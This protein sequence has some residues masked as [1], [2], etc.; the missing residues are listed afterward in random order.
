MPLN[1]RV[2]LGTVQLRKPASSP[3]NPNAEPYLWTVFFKIDDAHG[4]GDPVA[5]VVGTPGSHGNL[6]VGTV[7]APATIQVPRSI[8]RWDTGLS[9]LPNRPG[10]INGLVRAIVGM[11]AVL[12]EEDNVTDD[13]AEAGRRE[14]RNQVQK[15]IDAIA[16]D[17]V[18][19]LTFDPDA[20]AATIRSK[21]ED[22]I[23]GE[24]NFLED[25]WSFLDKDDFIGTMD[26]HAL[27][28]D[29]ESAS[30]P[31]AFS[32]SWGSAFAEWSLEGQARTF[33]ETRPRFSKTTLNFGRVQAG[34][35]STR[36]FTV[37]N[38][39]NQDL[40]F[41]LTKTGSREF[42][43]TTSTV[44]VPRSKQASVEMRFLPVSPGNKS[45][46]VVVK[47]QGSSATEATIA[48][49]GSTPTGPAP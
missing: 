1:V 10:T 13:G 38:F 44:T 28:G 14:L 19:A 18:S 6:G 2:E 39:T 36:S 48:L 23:Q 15:A 8:G 4:I 40:T 46:S 29:L 24:Q 16:A 26:W 42:R 3:F 22:A 20:L 5:T 37:T 27:Y 49:T 41:T 35:L 12:M 34:L 32:D 17:L 31:L 7:H 47:R 30:A 25:L 9:P 43:L 33:T 21:V 11:V 45:G